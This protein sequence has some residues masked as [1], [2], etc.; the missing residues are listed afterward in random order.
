MERGLGYD[1]ESKDGGEG[2]LYFVE[3]KGRVAGAD[4]VMPTRNE[5]LCTLNERKRFR[6]R[7]L[8]NRG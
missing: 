6:W 8:V 7:S 5:I 3:V 1:I 2:H 4:S